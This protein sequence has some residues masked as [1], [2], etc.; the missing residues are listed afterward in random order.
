MKPKSAKEYWKEK[1]GE[2]PQND[3]DKLA[4]VMM[5]EYALTI[6][7]GKDIDWQKLRDDFFIHCTE[8]QGGVWTEDI[9]PHALFEWF[10]R[11]LT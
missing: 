2:Y 11:K 1:F 7:G 6:Q 9:S 4:V 3:A 5:R 8:A 10:K